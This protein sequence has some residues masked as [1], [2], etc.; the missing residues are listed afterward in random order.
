M[1]IFLQQALQGIIKLIIGY[2]SW[3]K[4]K[5]A[6]IAV[7]GTE[8]SGEEKKAVVIAQ[9]KETGL[10][11]AASFLNLAIEIAVALITKKAVEANE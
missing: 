4:V 2:D 5:D 8:L 7:S 11:L 9:L 10:S 6:V 1:N 3:G